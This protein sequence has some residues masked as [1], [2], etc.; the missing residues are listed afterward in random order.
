MNSDV[1][2][3]EEILREAFIELVNT[4]IEVG[5]FIMERRATTQWKK[6]STR[7]IMKKALDLPFFDELNP[8]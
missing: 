3:S 2:T 1:R 7:A 5:A 4:M 8:R 6:R